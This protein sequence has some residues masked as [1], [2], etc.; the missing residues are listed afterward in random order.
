MS[1]GLLHHVIS[2]NCDGLHV[3]SGI[4][5]ENISELH[6]NIYVE[7]CVDCAKEHVS[8]CSSMSLFICSTSLCFIM[9]VCN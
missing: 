6:G 3:L 7:Y 8:R 2:Q 9:S 4:A 5:R 1:R